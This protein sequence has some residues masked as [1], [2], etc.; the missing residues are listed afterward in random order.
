MIP[1]VRL[2][3]ERLLLREFRAD[4]FDAYARMCGDAEVMEFLSKNGATLSR[5]DAW[6][7]MAMFAGHWALR[8]YGIWALEERETGRFVGRAGLHFPEG[9]PGQEVGWAL[10]REYW[11]RGLAFEAARAAIGFAFGELGWTQVISVIH[12]GN[13]R[14]VALAERL[15][16][17]LDGQ[18]TLR[19]ITHDVY[20][21]TAVAW[22]RKR[23]Q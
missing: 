16:E 21:L 8:G 1:V 3:T 2:E 17:A 4:D 18:A 14:S 15:G 22:D 12:P 5:E 9:W 11:G 13:R 23:R 10:C 19:G 20:R 6:R 7:Q